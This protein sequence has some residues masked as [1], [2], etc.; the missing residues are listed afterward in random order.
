MVPGSAPRSTTSAPAT[1]TEARALEDATA[2]KSDGRRVPV[3]ASTATLDVQ[4]Q[5]LLCV[6][7]ADLTQQN[8]QLREIE[9][10][11]RAQAE[12]M[13]ELEL[14]QAALTEQATHDALTGLPNRNLLI[15]RLTQSI[16][17]AERLGKS[18]G[19]IFVDLDHFKSINDTGGHAAGDI[20]LREVAQRLL[21][22]VRPMDSVARLG[23]DEFVLLLP[24]LD[25]ATDAVAVAK[26]V[27]TIL[28]PPI[29]L[30]HGEAHVTAS[31]GISVSDRSV[32][33]HDLT[34]E[35][36]LQQADS[37]MYN[38]KSLGGSHT[39]LFD[40]GSTG[41]FHGAD[42]DTWIMRIREALDEDRFV[43]HA[44][45][46]VDLE[47][48][49]VVQRELL[50]RMR[51]RSGQLIPPLAFLPTAETSGLITEIDRR[52]IA[53]A[54]RLAAHGEPVAVNLSAAS[55]G[56]LK[57]LESIERGLLASDADPSNLVFEITETALMRNMARAGL[58]VERLVALGCR[59]ALDD[60][61]TGYG[62]FTYLKRLPVQCLKIDIEFVRH[63]PRS[64]PDM[65]V[66]RAI[67]A[68][69]RDFG[70]QTIAEGVENE[71]SAKVLRELGVTLAQGYL[72]GAPESIQP[73]GLSTAA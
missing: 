52:V 24:A 33:D 44:Q 45:P 49:T 4:S 60:F 30:V 16:V 47:T 39:E 8:A 66:V 21:G 59:L 71:D 41:A 65:S 15:D 55:A 27:A 37:A 22:A 25:C 56:D 32:L 7:F 48:G 14:A 13:L 73:R 29:R 38:A 70:Q 62:G 64:P 36:L 5:A 9:R 50:L 28:D 61:G 53:Q 10:L 58:F 12:R 46:I 34:P 54:T 67:V 20:V 51:D 63:L 31:I 2:D 40:A 3:R 72:F 69:A 17:L 35:S 1:A 11:G 26:R 23:G 19:L 18:T 6:T 43:L 42:R 68:L 57:V